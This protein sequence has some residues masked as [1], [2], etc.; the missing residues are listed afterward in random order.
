MPMRS[1]KALFVAGSHLFSGHLLAL[2]PSFLQNV[3]VVRAL[4]QWNFGLFALAFGF[5]QSIQSFLTFRTVEALTSELI[6]SDQKDSVHHGRL[7]GSALCADLGTSM[8]SFALVVGASPF[9]VSLSLQDRSSLPLFFILSFITILPVAENSWL[10]LARYQRKFKQM[11]L[12]PAG[13]VILQTIAVTIAFLFQDLTVYTLAY[14]YVGTSALRALVYGHLLERD[15]R[16]LF[17]VSISLAL[18]LDAMRNR[19]AM[20]AFWVFMRYGYISGS[21][22]ALIKSSDILLLGI[23]RSE[24]DVGIYKLAKSLLGILQSI[25]HSLAVALFQDL[26]QLVTACSWQVLRL[27]VWHVTW[28]WS[29]IIA[30]GVMLGSVVAGP[31]IV[32]VYGEALR[33]A[34]EPFV[35]MLFAF[36]IPMA[37]FWANPLLLALRMLKIN[38]VS[39]ATVAICFLLT[40][41]LFV[42]RGG[43]VA[44]GISLGGAWSLAALVAAAASVWEIRRQLQETQHAS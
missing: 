7:I 9:F 37:L 26:V 23:W 41:V 38:L 30:V 1:I 34:T 39:N 42:P 20:S 6:R 18:L 36:A 32:A 21:I 43:A 35:A 17:G 12:L 19:A 8:L 10:S 16:A 15:A 25:S 4:G 5:C 2:V 11:A 28:I 29:L 24:S 27:R 3:L 31:V 22:T 14:I 33:P 13:F 40:S 44:M